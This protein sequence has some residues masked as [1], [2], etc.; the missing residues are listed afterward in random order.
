[1]HT[2]VFSRY[3]E[4]FSTRFKAIWYYVNK[5]MNSLN[6]NSLK[7]FSALS[8]Q[9]NDYGEKIQGENTSTFYS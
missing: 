3:D 5:N 2:G 7:E 6:I 4:L 1:M 9:F 8:G